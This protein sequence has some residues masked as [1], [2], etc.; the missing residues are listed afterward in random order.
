[1][2]TNAN[3]KR[4]LLKPAPPTS[5]PNTANGKYISPKTTKILNNNANHNT[6]SSEKNI[7]SR[8]SSQS[9]LDKPNIAKEDST[10]C[11]FEIQG[12]SPSRKKIYYLQLY[13]NFFFFFYVI[14]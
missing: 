1:M 2:E 9:S 4:S 5:S 7:S 14:N 12:V 10:E 8:G 11:L 3:V 6:T 13:I